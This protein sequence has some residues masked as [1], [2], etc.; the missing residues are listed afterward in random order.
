[1]VEKRVRR[2]KNVVVVSIGGISYGDYPFVLLG[3]SMEAYF[4]G[5]FVGLHLGIR[6]ERILSVR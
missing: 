4:C 1:M 2:N 5:D 6:K 3:D